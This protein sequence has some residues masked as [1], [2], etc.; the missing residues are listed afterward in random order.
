MD[1]PII[2]S[3]SDTIRFPNYGE[4][5]VGEYFASGGNAKIYLCSSDIRYVIKVHTPRKRIDGNYDDSYTVEHKLGIKGSNL[6]IP[7]AHTFVDLQP[8]RGQER[9]A[10][11]LL[12]HSL[13][14]YVMIQEFIKQNDTVPA[15]TCIDLIRRILEAYQDLHGKGWLHGDV[16][17]RNILIHPDKLDVQI[18][19]FEWAQKPGSKTND[20]VDG[21][22]ETIPPEVRMGEPKTFDSEF[23]S[24]CVIFMKLIEKQVH[25]QIRELDSIGVLD[26]IKETGNLESPLYNFDDKH[27]ISDEILTIIENGT[28]PNPSSR[29][30]LEELILA[31]P[32][33]SNRPKITV[34]L[35]ESSK[36][37]IQGRGLMGATILFDTGER[38]RIKKGRSKIKSFYSMKLTIDWA[39]TDECFIDATYEDSKQRVPIKEGMSFSLGDET[40]TLSK[41]DYIFD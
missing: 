29:T 18:I 11:V 5:T 33:A 38:V 22:P 8:R 36:N 15:D 4:F 16:S 1:L 6:C 28:I 3:K 39:Q 24:L 13:A 41:I 21:T 40:V 37:L 17:E 23:W 30:T 20:S 2:V 9:Y 10:L 12:M 26:Y 31:L 32:K 34:N 25:N 35:P 7:I 14:D 27:K 19:D